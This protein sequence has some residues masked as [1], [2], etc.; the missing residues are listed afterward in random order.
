[1]WYPPI[2]LSIMREVL[3]NFF[4]ILKAYLEVAQSELLFKHPDFHTVQLWQAEKLL[5][6]ATWPSTGLCVSLQKP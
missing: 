6:Y 3:G 2:L 5:P 4:R 1:M